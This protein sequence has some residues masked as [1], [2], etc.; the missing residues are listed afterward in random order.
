MHAAKL[1]DRVVTV[2]GE[3]PRVE[4]L[5]PLDADVIAVAAPPGQIGKAN[6]SRNN[7]RSDLADRE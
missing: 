6:S 5:R 3:H 4:L 7:R 2:F 1:C